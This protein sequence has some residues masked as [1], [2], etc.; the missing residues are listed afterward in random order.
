VVE[1]EIPDDMATRWFYLPNLDGIGPARFV[2]VDQLPDFN[3]NHAG[4][5]VVP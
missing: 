1:A 2:E 5:R 3:Q 4:V